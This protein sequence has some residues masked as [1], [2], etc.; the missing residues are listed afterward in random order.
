MIFADLAAKFV[1]NPAQRYLATSV[2]FVSSA[3]MQIILSDD[4]LQKG[5][6]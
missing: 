2:N 1:A 4:K 5:L 6:Q 3:F